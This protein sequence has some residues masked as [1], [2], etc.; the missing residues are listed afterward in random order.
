MAEEKKEKNSKKTSKKKDKEKKQDFVKQLKIAY[1]TLEDP[2]KFYKTILL[3]LVVI[4]VLVFLMPFILEIA[5][6]VPLNF[7]PITFIVGGIVP[8][9]LGIFYPFISW[10]NKEADINGKMHFFITHLRVLAISDLSLR[11]IINILGGKPVYGSLGEE[12]KKIS[13]LSTQWRV[14]LAKSFQFISTRTPSKIL[15]DFLDRFSQSLSSGVEH[16]E[17]IETEQKAV[18]QEYKTMYETSNENITILNEVYVSLLIAIIFVMSLGIVLP[19]I[20]GAESMNTFVYLSS[21]LL[22]MSEGM[23]LYLLKS[24]VPP[25]EIWHRTGEKG[26]L[27]ET[28]GKVFK[29]SV[30]MCIL[31]GSFLFFA[32]YGL[33]VPLLDMVPF[34]IIF[35]ISI[36]PLLITG[37]KVFTEEGDISRKEMNFLGFL[38][39]LGSI[40]S[41]RGGKI[42]ESI[43]YLSE[44]DY[45]VLSRHIKNLYRRL[46]TRINDD[47]SWE[48]FGVD[49]GSNYI[50]RS[51]EMFRE[52]TYAAA[53]PRKASRMI[54]ENIRKI[55]DLR[56]KK[57]AIVNTSTALFAGVTFGISFAVYVS[58]VISEHLNNIMMGIGDPFTGIGEIDVGSLLITVPPG[59]YTNL[60]IIIFTVFIIHSFIIAFTIKTLRGSHNLIVLLYFVPLVWIVAV[61]CAVVELGLSGYL[62][63]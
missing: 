34:E 55:R 31:L 47:E 49:T 60:S 53:N 24:M 27:E 18:L 48:W 36:T 51:S 42:N 58:L 30:L 5:V 52:A 12:M 63:V 59:T 6:P 13:A 15:K 25:D 11:D 57:M 39:A 43:Y 7:N 45:G 56:I 20:M 37:I 40:S 17:F 29:S 14:P 23:L 61:T 22:I 32:K 35:A 10:K 21:F 8:I 9:F 1:R 28:L 46:R 4:G 41:M 50:Q 33:S 54:A 3:P 62:V 2:K 26:E 44:K 16:R 38:P 19:F